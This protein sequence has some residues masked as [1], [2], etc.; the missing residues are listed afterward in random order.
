[1]KSL[2]LIIL[3]AGTLPAQPSLLSPAP[4]PCVPVNSHATPEARALLKTICALSGKQILSGQHNY[5]NHLSQH[6]ERLAQLVGKQPFVW[7]SDF[8]FTGGD[9]KD[10]IEGRTAMIEE[11]IRQ[12]AAGSIITLMWHAVRPTDD[13]PV[14]PGIGW[15]QS[16]QNRLNDDEWAALITPGTALNRRWIAQ[17]DTIAPYLRKLQDARIPVLWRPY[18]ENNGNWFWWGARPGPNGFAALWRM[19]Y[20]RMVHYHRLDHLLWV[21]NPNAPH[22]TAGPY[23][24]FHPGSPYID[25]YA[26][27][28]YGPYEQSHHDDLLKLA[29][30]KPIALGEVGRPPALEILRNQPMWTWFMGWSNIFNR[31]ATPDH[32]A[33]FQRPNTLSRGDKLPEMGEWMPIFDGKTLSSWTVESKPADRD[34]G[35]WSVADG[36]IQADSLGRKDHDYVWLV[37][38]REFADFELRLQVRGF[39]ESTGNSGVQV[40]SRFD[41][42]RGWLHGPQIDVHPPAP[43]RT[44]LIYDETYETRR[45]IHPSLPDWKITPEQGP[46]KWEWDPRGWNDLHIIC[47]GTRIITTVNGIR[48]TDEDL[49]A[50]LADDAHR[51]HNVGRKGHIALQLHSKDELKIQFRHL[52]VRELK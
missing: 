4:A 35:F 37:Y 51:K 11:A 26:A 40:R 7:G 30:G 33:L 28:I 13:E 21:W 19:T 12:H 29:A 22:R 41:R 42:E 27:D 36:A 44:G 10:S 9:D 38:D 14:Q 5:P 46:K 24:D 49:G 52:Q 43:W 48:I 6:S 17:I 1:M 50:V 15:R 2:L 34:K 25:V 23:H 3:S 20:E 45:W 31:E 16:V 39:P 8:G 32:L 18:H 47:L